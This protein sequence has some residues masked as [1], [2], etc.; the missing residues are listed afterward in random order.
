M[1]VDF[2]AIDF[3]TANGFRG[4]ACAVGLV[5]VRDGAVVDT[6]SSLLQPPQGFDHFDPRN[7]SIHGIRPDDVA[8]A[9]RF[10][11]AYPD[12]AEFIGS[13]VVLAHNAAFD[14]GVIRAGLQASE[15]GASKL[16]YAC[17]V[18]LARKVYDLM[19]YSLPFAAHAAGFD[20]TEHHD[21]LADARACAAIGVDAAHRL[22]AQSIQEAVARAGLQVS[23]MASFKPGDPECKALRDARGWR[24]AG[25]T[26]PQQFSEPWPLE[27]PNPEPNMDA[28]PANPLYGQRVVF[29]G[30]LGIPRSE[31]KERAAAVGAHTADR[32]TTQ[33]SVLVVGDG[34]VAEDLTSG[35]MTR[36]ARHALARRDMG[37]EISVMSEAEFLQ[38]VGGHWPHGV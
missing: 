35:R 3:E 37:Q 6:Y 7:V 30:E 38:A 4:S 2:V 32:V 21:A 5:K 31:A 12:I 28:D 15:V 29:T 23:T 33:T 34:F 1:A 10:A 36:K 26:V 13:D 20:L 18:Q 17:T 9:P 27:G 11:A 8:A 24:A 25:H 16:A 19:S 14:I 22:G